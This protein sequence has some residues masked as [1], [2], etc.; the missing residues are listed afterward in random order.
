[1]TTVRVSSSGHVSLKNL[2]K[3]LNKSIPQIL[4]LLIKKYETELFFTELNESILKV[5]ENEKLWSE[6]KNEQN[7]LD[8]TLNDDLEDDPYYTIDELKELLKD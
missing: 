7:S 2:S 8:G 5:K 4:D 6:L 3:K 1:M